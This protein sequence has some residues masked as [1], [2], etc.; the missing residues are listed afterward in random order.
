VHRGGGTGTLFQKDFGD[1]PFFKPQRYV[2]RTMFYFLINGFGKIHPLF[3]L[4]F[5]AT[6][7][8]LKCLFS[9]TVLFCN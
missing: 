7:Y 9:I 4:F 2:S 5:L 8:V 1:H 3:K 6:A